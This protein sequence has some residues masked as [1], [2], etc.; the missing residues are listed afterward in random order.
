M[1]ESIQ[2]EVVILGRQYKIACRP[3]E[4][5]ELLAA[6]GYLDSKMREIRDGPKS[7]GVEKVSVMAGLN[8]AHE[9][10]RARNA[11]N[12]DSEDIRRRIVDMQVAI[13]QAMVQQDQ[14]F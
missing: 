14:L 10:L 2:L 12:F 11:A 4:Q 9:L 7:P 6:V 8:I 3:E 1:S 13:E 5:A